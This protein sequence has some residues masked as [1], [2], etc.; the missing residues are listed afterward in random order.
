MTKPMTSPEV[1]V[2]EDPAEAARYVAE[3]FASAIQTTP[4]I[5]LGLATGGTPVEVYRDLVRR[6]REQGLDFSRVTSF[7]LDE[8]VGLAGDH[9]QSYRFF[10]QQQLFD[11]INIALGRT[12][13]PD[14]T[15][16]DL[17]RHVEQYEQAIRD[18]GGIELQ[19]LGIG[20]NGHI[21]FNE[22]GSPIDSRTRVVDLSEE[23]IQANARFFESI[24]QVPRQAITMGIGTILEANRIVLMATGPSKAEAIAA[25][26]EGEC[27]PDNPASA[28]QQHNDVVF[29]L[30]SSAASRLS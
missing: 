21:A 16:S 13:V 27:D 22:P 6:H 26:I 2:C 18:S 25:A 29:V 1:V 24:D 15:A 10:M 11:H 4:D 23:T 8:Y 12:H 5:V 30:D 20:N 19:L 7:N 3:L 14:G 9:P 17:S 28:L